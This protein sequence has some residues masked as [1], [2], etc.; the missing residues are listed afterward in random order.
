MPPKKAPVP[1]PEPEVNE[2][3]QSSNHLAFDRRVG[4]YGDQTNPSLSFRFP[5]SCVVLDGDLLLVTD[6][7]NAR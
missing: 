5:S 2:A 4:V 3:P 7:W 1:E 6:T